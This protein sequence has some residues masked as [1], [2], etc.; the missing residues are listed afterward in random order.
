M[1]WCGAEHP[2]DLIMYVWPGKHGSEDSPC[3]SMCRELSKATSNS[4]DLS[5]EEEEE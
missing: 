1:K 2:A 5:M 4:G 3:V